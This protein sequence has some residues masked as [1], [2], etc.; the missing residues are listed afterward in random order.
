[1]VRILCPTFVAALVAIALSTTV[2][3]QG[4]STHQD[5][6]ANVALTNSKPSTAEQNARDQSVEY[7][8][9]SPA[10]E[11]L[12]AEV[13]RSGAKPIES[14]KLADSALQTA[15]ELKDITGEAMVQELRG[16]VLQ[17]LQRPDDAET[18]WEKA[19]YAW[20]A[21]GE[22]ILQIRAL[23]QATTLSGTRQGAKELFN[24]ILSAAKREHGCAP[25][26]VEML[27]RAGTSA[28]AAEQRQIGLDLLSTALAFAEKCTP[29]STVFV[30]TLNQ[31][32]AWTLKKGANDSGVHFRVG[33]EYYV[34]AL[35][36]AEK[37]APDSMLVA[38][39]LRGI[40]R[41]ELGTENFPSARDYYLR[42][43]AIQQRLAPESLEVAST[44]DDLGELATLESELQSAGQYYQ[45]ALAIQERLAPESGDVAV[46]LRRLGVVQIYKGELSS[47]SETIQR[48]LSIEEKLH[49]VI[50][51]DLM[52]L[53]LVATEQGDLT[54]ARNYFERV[55]QIVMRNAPHSYVV[56]AALGNLRE[57]ASREGDWNAALDYG[58]RAIAMFQQ[59]SAQRD[60][61]DEYV[62]LGEIFYE[63]GKFESA[64]QYYRSALEIGENIA[65]TSLDVA[66]SLIHLEKKRANV[67]A[68]SKAATE[69]Y[70]RAL[71]IAEKSAPSSPET[72]EA[73][74][75][76]GELAYQQGDLVSAEKYQ[77]RAIEL[78]ERTLGPTHPDLAR[79][80]HDLALTL[81]VS[82]KSSEALVLASRAEQI[83]REHL[84]LSIQALSERQALAYASARVSSLP[85]LLTLAADNPKGNAFVQEAFDSLILSRALVFDEMAARH[86]TIHY[87]ED[88]EVKRL[89]SQLVSA[90]ARLSTL[91]IRGIGDKSP[92]IY[93][94]LLDEARKEKELAEQSLAE[95]SSAFRR[96]QHR[97]RV[98]LREVSANLPP[99]AAL[100]AFAR[101][102]R[103]SL[104]LSR[105]NGE[106]PVTVPSYV[107]FILRSGGASATVVPLGTAKEIEISLRDWQK[108]IAQQAE[109]GITATGNLEVAYRKTGL[110]LRKK[111]WD[112]VAAKIRN[113]QRIF[114]IPDGALHLVNFSSLPIGEAG[115]LIE[116]SP[117]IHYL[118]TERDLIALESPEPTH[119]LFVLGAP[120][121]DETKLFASLSTTGPKSTAQAG[122]PT[123]R[124][125]RSACKAFQ[126]MHFEPLP[127]SSREIHEVAALWSGKVLPR[128][129]GVSP[130]FT[131]EPT[132]ELE[133]AMASEPALKSQAQGKR[134]LHLATHAFFMDGR[135]TSAL[136]SSDLRMVSP[137]TGDN[138]LLLSGLALAGANHRN[139]AGEDEDDGI[140]TA[141]EIASLDLSGTD[142]AVLSACDTGG[143]ELKAGEGVFG[144]RRAF[145][146]AGVNTVI[147]S[148][149]PVE[150]EMTRQ[151]MKILYQEHFI[152]G[153]DTDASV[154]ASSLTILHQ[155]RA[156]HLSTHPFFWAALIAVGNS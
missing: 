122:T 51:P 86:R 59:M 128:F 112:P 71:D 24:E 150:D 1:V 35:S 104:K 153:K 125:T 61:A 145:Q 57:V 23:M 142:W 114:V 2:L 92:E 53:G 31:L 88:P 63:Q 8:K 110:V 5:S 27:D 74:N 52:D 78:R 69:Y 73:L 151:W 76:L 98:G 9:P 36:L 124:G 89:N 62:G 6:S 139:A 54:A 83:G 144:L 111:V 26:F 146:I 17:E 109:Y 129:R 56:A 50:F 68:N 85:L 84:R 25:G 40:G 117:V 155:R 149:W 47:A 102:N 91:V 132:V 152:D 22:I 119:G 135:C 45:H 120:A 37:L 121:F 140:I 70:T 81:A 123:F 4:S 156:K 34:R 43:L 101:Y 64:G 60:L 41:A 131:Q 55:L 32:A 93:L 108:Q 147:M 39:S 148:L 15:R 20:A 138:P 49:N 95:K 79:S 100:V 66:N 154:Q 115:Y 12:L 141:E 42:A 72:A 18:A 19:A 46:S 10:V 143:G 16:R 90:R 67:Q 38:D 133:G 14:L 126:S 94:K 58:K 134:V 28:S 99:G 13:S 116:S 21:S 7:P 96:Q 77:R 97:N 106:A 11:N 136:D 82:G 105:L 80:L 130:D 103:H 113:C 75:G 65:P 3:A 30:E 29:N 137:I 118:S 44:L 127:G 107:A 48:A 87:S 33:K